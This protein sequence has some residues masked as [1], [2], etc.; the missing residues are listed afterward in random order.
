MM[1]WVHLKDPQTLSLSKRA[2][3]SP[4]GRVDL[5]AHSGPKTS[6]DVHIAPWAQHC[7]A[8]LAEFMVHEVEATIW[9]MWGNRQEYPNSVGH[10]GCQGNTQTVWEGTGP[11]ERKDQGRVA[12]AAADHALA[13]GFSGPMF[14]FNST[15]RPGVF[16]PVPSAPPALTPEPPA[17][18]FPAGSISSPRDGTSSGGSPRGA[19]QG[20][21]SKEQPAEG[22]STPSPASPLWSPGGKLSWGRKEPAGLGVTP[23]RLE[24]YVAWNLNTGCAV[25]RKDWG[26]E[27]AA[28]GTVN[29]FVRCA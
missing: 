24:R 1:S 15:P 11:K 26:R 14:H 6:V 17:Q 5:P 4:A 19:A 3:L 21:P 20:H 28:F 23:H 9:H 2:A 12:K 29:P 18:G 13:Q 10:M 25:Q 16:P 27:R 8:P 22:G 7:Q